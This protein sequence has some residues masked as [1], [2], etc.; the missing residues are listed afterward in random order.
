MLGLTLTGFRDRLQ[1]TYLEDRGF[2]SGRAFIRAMLESVRA[3]DLFLDAGCGEAKLR[4]RLP[5]GV[6]Y[7]G[8][9]GYA[10]AQNNEYANWMMRPDVVADVHHL[11]FRDE[12]FATVALIHVLEHVREPLQ[13]LAEIARVLKPGGQLFLDVPFL[14]EIHHAPHDISRPTTYG[15]RFMTEKVGLEVVEIRPSGGYFRCLA[16]I[17]EEAPTVV[18]GSSAGA[19]L[20]RIGVAYP[21]KGLG[22]L[23]RK[24]QYALDLQD[25]RQ[26]FTTGYHCIFRKPAA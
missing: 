16:H 26:E 3:G 11:P 10:G 2:G 13:V 17:L 15:L 1:R 25:E 4:K 14:H 18:S 6:T 19:R 24:T 7:V 23:L 9:D 20:T 8:L 22:W 21:L 5:D 12:T